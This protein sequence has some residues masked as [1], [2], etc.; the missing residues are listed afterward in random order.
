MRSLYVMATGQ[1]VGKTTMSLG[2]INLL[3]S[4]GLSVRFFK[5]VGQQYV[6]R[7]GIK[8]DKDAVLM[9]SAL[10]V[11]G[12]LPEM[13]PVTVPRGFVEKYLF[14]P[15]VEPLKKRIF[16][17]Y[18]HQA[19]YCDVMVVEGTGHAGVGSCFDLSNA[20]VAAMLDSRAILVVE[21]GIGSALDQVALN[22]SLFRERNVEVIG[23]IAN[24]VFP[25]K[26]DRIEKVLRQGLSNMGLKLL[27]AIPYDEGLTYP[28]V[29]QV[30][31]VLSAQILCGEQ[32]LNTRIENILVAAM[33]PQN[34]LPRIGPRSLMITPGDRIDN[35]LVSLSSGLFRGDSQNSVV[36][37]VLT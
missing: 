5:P 7:D 11:G 35:I 9:Q 14:D 17:A 23:V 31:D 33:E 22:I 4:H 30:V 34:V 20:D 15:D 18:E 2:L 12:T 24:K 21:G 3:E 19:Q 16:E 8:I 10:S 36:G 28:R 26:R 32:A 25:E 37:L 27:G 29:G 1:H 13:S 6:E